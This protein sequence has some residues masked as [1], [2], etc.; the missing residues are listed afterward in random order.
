MTNMRNSKHLAKNIAPNAAAKEAF[1]S[2]TNFPA[3]GQHSPRA[4]KR[5]HIRCSLGLKNRWNNDRR[6]NNM[7]SET[8]AIMMIGKTRLADTPLWILSWICRR[9]PRARFVLIS[10]DEDRTFLNLKRPLAESVTCQVCMMVYFLIW[11]V[12]S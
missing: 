10:F 12:S 7:D 11:V 6:R 1:F 8:S 9:H 5:L 2:D 3:N 4:Q